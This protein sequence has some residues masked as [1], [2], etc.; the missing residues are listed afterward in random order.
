MSERKK[1]SKSKQRDQQPNPTQMGC[2]ITV[3]PSES[4]TLGSYTG[5]PMQDEHP[6]Q[7]ADDL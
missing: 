4:D 2:Q 5:R 7:D 3:P 6:T 1:N